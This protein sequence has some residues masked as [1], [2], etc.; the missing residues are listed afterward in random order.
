MPEELKIENRV[1]KSGLIQLEMAEFFP[2]EEIVEYDL[3]QNLWQ[4][5]ALKEKDFREFIKTY[6]WDQFNNKHVAIHCS[7]DAII[8]SW[9]YML[10]STALLGKALSINYGTKNAVEQKLLIDSINEI[11]AQEFLDSR[12][13]IKG[14]GDRDVSESAWVAITNKLQPVVKSLMYGEP[15]STVPVYKRPRK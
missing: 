4:G 7:A 9:A 13:V 12:I 1:A 5:L 2:E 15:C 10:L 14:C 11:N 3:A 6:N 8:P